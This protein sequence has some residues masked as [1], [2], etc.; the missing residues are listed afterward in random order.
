[1]EAFFR[2]GPLLARASWFRTLFEAEI[3]TETLRKLTCLIHQA[4]KILRSLETEV[5]ERGIAHR[6]LWRSKPDAGA[7]RGNFEG[8]KSIQSMTQEPYKR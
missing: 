1:V 3:T 7:S 2:S 6:I 5:Y 4:K 8:A